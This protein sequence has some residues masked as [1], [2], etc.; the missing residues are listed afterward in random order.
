MASLACATRPVDRRIAWDLRISDDPSVAAF[1]L[2]KGR[3]EI[4]LPYVRRMAFDAPELAMLLAHE[5]AHVL[6]GHR[7]ERE[8]DDAGG[9]PAAEQEAIARA[10]A[11]EDEADRIGFALARRAGWRAD[12]LLRFFDKLAANEAAGT[13][14]RS[15]RSARDR[16]AAMHAAAD[17]MP[18]APEKL[19]GSACAPPGKE[20][21][22]AGEP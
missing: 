9:D 3:L 8:R 1:A 4:G 5:M 13:F 21:T 11:Q 2:G 16:A 14:S 7:R 19:P 17:A 20:P 22:S 10:M 12:G 18:E 6:A 15:H